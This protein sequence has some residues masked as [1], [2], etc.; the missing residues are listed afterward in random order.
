MS[1]IHDLGV[2]DPSL[3]LVR[4]RREIASLLR[5]LVTRAQLVRLAIE[6]G[7]DTALTVLLEVDED[8][9]I[10]VIDCTRSATQN[11]LIASGAGLGFDTA[12]DRI[13]IVFEAG[14]AEPCQYQDLP[15]FRI[16]LPDS[17]YRLQRREAYRVPL[18]CPIQIP[19]RT[20]QGPHLVEAELRNI[21]ASGIAIVVDEVLDG[22]IGRVYPDCRI[23]LP[24]GEAIATALRIA[25]IQKVALPGGGTTRHLGCE[26]L[27]MSSQALTALQRHLLWQERQQIARGDGLD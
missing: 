16:A 1:M 12:L 3:Y 13:R 14:H 4:S 15:A 2:E 9:G 27:G 11:H 24:G 5:R 8:S 23:A 21:S 6:G 19:Y 26:F 17:L 7:S 22:T 18:R 20:A 10:V 25:N